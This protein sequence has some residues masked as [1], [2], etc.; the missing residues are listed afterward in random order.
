VEVEQRSLPRSS[1]QEKVKAWEQI[2]KS[3]DHILT[4]QQEA[5]RQIQSQDLGHCSLW[6]LQENLWLCLQCGNLGCGRTQFGRRSN[7]HGLE[8]KNTTGHAVV[9]KLG[10]IT[11]EGTADIFCYQCGED[12]I[13]HNLG[14][15][16]AH[17]GIVLAECQKS[18]KSLAEIQES[19]NMRW[20]LSIFDEDGHKLQNGAT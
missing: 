17:W 9:V 18:E 12:R 3:C 19:N 8:H 7:A 2:Y 15:H 1:L 11:P 16:L 20:H 13:D 14:K 10:T 4:L 6:D 5:P